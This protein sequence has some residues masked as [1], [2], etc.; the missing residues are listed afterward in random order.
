MPIMEITVI[1]L[2]TKSPS[3]SKYVA[4]LI[5]VLKKEKDIKYELTSMSTIIEAES[6]DKLFV[7]AKKMHQLPFDKGA[8]RVVTS[9]NIDERLDKKSTIQGKKDSVLDKLE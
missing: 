5:D 4:E 8:M 9:I 1:P 6:L 2:G 7:V 3:V